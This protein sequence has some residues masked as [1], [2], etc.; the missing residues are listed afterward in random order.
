MDE[1]THLSELLTYATFYMHNSAI[2]NIKTIISNF[3][4]LEEI[5]T[6]KKMLW[7]LCSD[8]LEQYIE[9]KSTD[10]RSSVEASINDIFEALSKLDILGKV[11]TFV[12]KN[13][14]KL[15]SRQPEELNMICIINRL[16]K[17][18]QQQIENIELLQSHEEKI[19][20]IRTSNNNDLD[21]KIKYIEGKIKSTDE[22]ILDFLQVQELKIGNIK[23]G[24]MESLNTSINDDNNCNDREENNVIKQLANK[25]EAKDNAQIN[26]TV[27]ESISDEDDVFENF[28]DSC[29]P[30]GKQ[31]MSISDY[32]TTT[33]SNNNN[34]NEAVSVVFDTTRNLYSNAA[35]KPKINQ[36]QDREDIRP[37]LRPIIVEQERRNRSKYCEEDEDG[38]IRRIKKSPNKKNEEDGI[39]GA[40]TLR[41]VWIS[42]VVQGNESNVKKYLNNR[43]IRVNNV[44]KTSHIDSQFKSFKIDILNTDIKLVMSNRF[45]PEGVNCKIWRERNNSKYYHNSKRG[46]FFN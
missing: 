17:L 43:N 42:K 21:D 19:H 35:K 3:Y 18:E 9:R 25:S 20:N 38:F 23:D 41:T 15:P 7:A 33:I 8:S 28:L 29:K 6:A 14:D 37:P 31:S 26:K 34:D 12:A 16:V 30:N 45:W 10:K 44:K 24:S 4:P 22:K 36:Y 40:P 32:I 2:N 1:P 27:A 39:I 11:P 5:I 46:Q 13:I